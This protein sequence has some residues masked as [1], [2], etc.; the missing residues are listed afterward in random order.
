MFWGGFTLACS[1][2]REDP[3]IEKTWYLIQDYNQADVVFRGRVVRTRLIEEKQAEHSLEWQYS[4]VD[5]YETYKG[6][7]PLEVITKSVMTCCMCGQKLNWT[8]ILVN[9]LSWVM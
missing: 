2:L 3:N 7:V 4:S 6:R 8:A 9:I 5:V 1:P